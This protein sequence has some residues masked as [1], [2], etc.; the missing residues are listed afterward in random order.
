MRRA[1][2]KCK[3]TKLGGEKI[4]DDQDEDEDEDEGV[5]GGDREPWN[6]FF[7]YRV[8]AT[9]YGY[10]GSIY[11]KIH[12]RLSLPHTR[13]PNRLLHTQVPND[14]IPSMTDEI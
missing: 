2:V 11:L 12:F 5:N 8:M 3:Q 1:E 14:I 13:V 6:F 10:E 4:I 7:E 9:H